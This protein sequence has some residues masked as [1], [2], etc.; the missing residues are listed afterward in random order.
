MPH[1]PKPMVFRKM[2]FAFLKTWSWLLDTIIVPSWWFPNK[3]KIISHL[4]DDMILFKK[5]R[6]HGWSSHFACMFWTVVHEIFTPLIS[7]RTHPLVTSGFENI[8]NL[9]TFPA[10]FC[11]RIIMKDREKRRTK[12][13]KIS[14]FSSCIYYLYEKKRKETLRIFVF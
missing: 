7:S 1:I 9:I 13:P 11:P 2:V 10:Y 5:W 8:Q 3:L 12:N 4:Q 14:S 6:C